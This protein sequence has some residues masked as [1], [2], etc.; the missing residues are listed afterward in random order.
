[1]ADRLS[2]NLSIV[3]IGTRIED[4]VQELIPRGADQVYVID[5]PTLEYFRV[6]PYAAVLTEPDSTNTNRRSDR[7]GHNMGRTIMPIMAV[8]LGAG[9]TADCTDLDID[10]EERLLI[11]YPARCRRKHHGYHQDSCFTSP[12]ATVRRSPSGPFPTIS[13]GR[14]KSSSRNSQNR[15]LLQGSSGC[16]L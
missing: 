16:L 12:N 11:Q 5:H 8:R 2:V 15:S 10:P 1:M 14:E 3:A 7:L 4:K 9:L 13:P 6:D